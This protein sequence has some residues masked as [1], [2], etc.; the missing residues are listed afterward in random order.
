MTRELTETQQERIVRDIINHKSESRAISNEPY[1]ED[2]I[3]QDREYFSTMS[4]EELIK[5]WSGRVG[6]WICSIGNEYPSFIEAWE[7]V[8]SEY[9]Q[10]AEWQ[11]EV[12]LDNGN[13]DY[14]YQFYVYET[15]YN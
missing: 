3:E 13:V 5:S 14:G 10:P 15:P 11:L 4:D 2:E 7:T 9:E 6:E 12:L 8:E 1:R